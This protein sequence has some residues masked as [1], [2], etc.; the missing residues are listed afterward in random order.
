MI[1]LEHSSSNAKCPA[2]GGCPVL[3]S[4]N[5]RLQGCPYAAFAQLCCEF[6]NET[7]ILHLRGAVCSY[8]LKQVAQELVAYIDGVRLVDNQI[9]VTRSTARDDSKSGLS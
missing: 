7:G 9:N 1:A 6:Q 3:I 2:P 4:V 5:R 8:Y